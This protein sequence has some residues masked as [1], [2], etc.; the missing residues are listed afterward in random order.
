MWIENSTYGISYGRWKK[1]EAPKNRLSSTVSV[2]FLFP[3]PFLKWSSLEGK[4]KKQKR[5]QR[6]QKLLQL[7][8]FLFLFP[9]TSSG[10]AEKSDTSRG[11]FVCD[12]LVHQY[13]WLMLAEHTVKNHQF[14]YAFGSQS[15]F[16]FPFLAW[17]NQTWSGLMGMSGYQKPALGSQ[18]LWLL[19]LTSHVVSPQYL[20]WTW[21]PG[22]TR[23]S[24]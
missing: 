14:W 1:N 4:K 7:F 20:G 16:F 23:G 18:T 19:L 17:P 9:K 24:C 8:D 13:H 3:K 12:D 21:M 6:F 5:P 15:N 11:T 22:F 10:S 2:F